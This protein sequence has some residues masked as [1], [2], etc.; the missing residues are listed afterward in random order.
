MLRAKDL[1]QVFWSL[2]S[3]STLSK[4]INLSF[5]STSTIEAANFYLPP[6]IRNSSLSSRKNL[7]RL[8]FFSPHAKLT[9]DGLRRTELKLD[10]TAEPL[11]PSTLQFSMSSSS[12]ESS[13]D[14]EPELDSM[15]LLSQKLSLT[16][17]NN[18]SLT[19]ALKPS[20]LPISTS[21]TE[22]SK[23]N[24]KRSQPTTLL[25]REKGNDLCIFLK[26][27]IIY[28]LIFIIALFYLGK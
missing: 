9:P 28:E 12:P 4:R 17:L 5:W 3:A 25:R 16:R 7:R 20:E 18:I 13:L 23:L 21:L 26:L 19:I 24:S 27:T 11:L 1:P 6:S 8:S 14:K 22:I 10:P 2:V 15:D